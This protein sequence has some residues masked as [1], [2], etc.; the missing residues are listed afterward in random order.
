MLTASLVRRHQ[1]LYRSKPE[2]ITVKFRISTGVMRDISKTGTTEAQR[3][4]RCLGD[5]CASVVKRPPRATRNARSDDRVIIARLTEGSH[6]SQFFSAA[7]G[8]DF[9]EHSRD[10]EPHAR[11]RALGLWLDVRRS[12]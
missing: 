5:L 3:T 7:T 4:L 10:G 9:G 2:R 8:V 6:A 1:I 11:V 12:A